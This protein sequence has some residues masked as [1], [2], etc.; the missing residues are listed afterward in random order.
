MSK[1]YANSQTSPVFDNKSSEYKADRVW[2]G[3]NER[4]RLIG[5]RWSITIISVKKIYTVAQPCRFVQISV[6]SP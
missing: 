3:V 2:G 6:I 5:V 1:K 4:L